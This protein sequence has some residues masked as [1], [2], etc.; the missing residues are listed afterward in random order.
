MNHKHAYITSIQLSPSIN[1][2]TEQCVRAFHLT[3]AVDSTTKGSE[4][5][6]I[7]NWRNVMFI[8]QTH[9]PPSHN[10]S[11]WMC[12]RYDAGVRESGGQQGLTYFQLDNLIVLGIIHRGP[13]LQGQRRWRQNRRL[14]HGGHEC[15]DSAASGKH[16]EHVLFL[17]GG[18]LGQRPESWGRTKRG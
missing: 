9:L 12:V 16:V 4:Y 14:A 1:E 2:S 8:N 17:V 13:L 7:I 18:K 5:L 3:I 6:S 10:R 11:I 15:P